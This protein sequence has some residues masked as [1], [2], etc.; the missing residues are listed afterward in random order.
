[1]HNLDFETVWILRSYTNNIDLIV[2]TT[3][4]WLLVATTAPVLIQLRIFSTL[5][6]LSMWMRSAIAEVL[7]SAIDGVTDL[8]FLPELKVISQMWCIEFWPPESQELLWTKRSRYSMQ[9][10]NAYKNAWNV[11]WLMPFDI[12]HYWWFANISKC[13]ILKLTYLIKTLEMWQGNDQCQTKKRFTVIL[14]HQLLRV[15]FSFF[16]IWFAQSCCYGDTLTVNESE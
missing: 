15:G 16:K 4:T 5:I 11:K 9:N 14:R 3:G 1:M 7:V 6:K 2:A 13:F 12:T 8:S 10:R